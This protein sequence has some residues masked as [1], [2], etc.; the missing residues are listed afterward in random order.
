MRP[1][2][3]Y[4]LATLMMIMVFP[5]IARAALINQSFVNE[6]RTDA[7]YLFIINDNRSADISFE[8]N[9]VS[10]GDDATDWTY[11]LFGSET[12]LMEGD[13]IDPYSG[14]FRVSFTDNSPRRN[15]NQFDFTLEWAE[16][17]GGV[18]VGQG[19]IYYQNGTIDR[20]D[21]NFTSTVP[22]PLPASAWLLMSGLAL[23]VGFRRYTKED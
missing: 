1:K 22:T 23:F 12:L 6:Y 19:S 8:T 4:S 18:S 15:T 2:T 11:T 13:P 10:F 17:L 16:Y 3:I 7:V 9:P 21:G 20:F 5:A 14:S